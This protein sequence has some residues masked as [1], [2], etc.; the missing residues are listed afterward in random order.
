MAKEIINVGVTANDG[1]GDTIRV[2]AQKINSNFTEIYNALST[3]NGQISV[4]SD[5]TAKDGLSVSTDAGSV[6]IG[7]LKATSF[8]LGV[9]KVDGTSITVDENGVVS[10]TPYSLPIA[11]DTE[12][13]GVKVDG[14]TIG[15]DENGSISVADGFISL[16]SLQSVVAD[17]TSFADFQARIASL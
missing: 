8:R 16:A 15:I 2:G 17:S 5:I 13:G 14:T 3:Q 12:L 4:V 7:G 6:L 10:A 1:L 11:S 9:V